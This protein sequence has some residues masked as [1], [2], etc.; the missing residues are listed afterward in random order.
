MSQEILLPWQCEIKVSFLVTIHPIETFSKCRENYFLKDDSTCTGWVYNYTKEKVV[1]DCFQSLLHQRDHLVSQG[2]AQNFV[3]DVMKKIPNL[4]DW[5]IKSE[6]KGEE[7]IIEEGIYLIP[8]ILME[9]AMQGKLGRES[10]K[11]AKYT[12]IG[13][14]IIK[15]KDLTLERVKNEGWIEN[16]QKWIM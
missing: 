15:R 14:P 4:R 9:R 12:K 11:R 6:I 5:E 10:L 8:T 1:C 13:V 7:I 2:I 16:I 3:Q